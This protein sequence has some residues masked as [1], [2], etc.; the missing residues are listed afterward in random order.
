MLRTVVA[1]IVCVA[2]PGA[3]T[4]PSSLHLHLHVAQAEHHHNA[5]NVTHEHHVVL[6]AH[7]STEQHSDQH[8]PRQP[9]DETESGLQPHPHGHV[10]S[11][12]TMLTELPGHTI[13][14]AVEDTVRPFS[15]PD[16]ILSRT[17]LNEPRAHAPPC[18]RSSPSRAPPA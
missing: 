17:V 13:Q 10:V 9:P 15:A 6:H 11:L 2:L 5:G 18:V 3:M 4:L 7:G 1:V 12:D 16:R 8:E 14:F